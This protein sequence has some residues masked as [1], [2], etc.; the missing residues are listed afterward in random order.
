MQDYEKNEVAMMMDTIKNESAESS[1]PIPTI[2]NKHMK[3][4]HDKGL[5]FITP[6]PSFENVK[7]GLYDARKKEQQV[8]RTI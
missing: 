7:H 2:Y 8:L 5:N 1:D 6:I 4:L 3:T